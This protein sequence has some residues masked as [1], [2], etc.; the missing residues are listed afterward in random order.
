VKVITD[1]NLNTRIA[2][3]KSTDRVDGVAALVI[4][5][6]TFLKAKPVEAASVYETHGLEFF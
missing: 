6:H 2:K 3:N 4:A 5:T 1:T